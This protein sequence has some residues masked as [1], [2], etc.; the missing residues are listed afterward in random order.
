M[1]HK[2]VL[3]LFPEI[4]LHQLKAGM[5]SRTSSVVFDGI[6]GIYAELKCLGNHF[7][8]GLE[9]IPGNDWFF[10]GYIDCRNTRSNPYVI[11]G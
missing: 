8:K 3:L 2:L 9:A 7:P 11:K 1:F 4:Y 6:R 5:F 10:K